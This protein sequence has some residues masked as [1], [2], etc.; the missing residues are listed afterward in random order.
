VTHRTLGEVPAEGVEGGAQGRPIGAFVLRHVNGAAEQETE[1]LG[2]G[3]AA[4]TSSIVS[5]TPAF[6]SPGQHRGREPG[7][8]GRGPADQQVRQAHPSRVVAMMPVRDPP[9][10]TIEKLGEWSATSVS[11]LER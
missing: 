7:T 2:E 10:M 3:T 9:S 1:P 4:G 8:L 11:Y 5:P 6:R